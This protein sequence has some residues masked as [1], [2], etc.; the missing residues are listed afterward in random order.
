MLPDHGA[1]LAKGAAGDYDAEFT[2]LA[3]RLVADGLGASTLLLG[4]QPDDDTTPW[5]V[6]SVTAA[7]WY[8]AYWDRIEAAMSAV[9]GTSFTFEWDPGDSGTS[10]VPPSAM[11]PGDAAVD[12]IGTDAFDEVPAGVPASQQ[13]GGVLG[14]ADGP[15]W[16]ATFAR[17]HHK[18]LAV[19]MWGVVPTADGG[20]GD[21]AA[22][23]TDVL[24]WAAGQGVACCV[25][26]DYGDWAVGGGGFPAAYAALVT[27]VGSAVD[28]ATS[29][30]GGTSP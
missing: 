1:T 4:S 27:A 17:E 19:A 20:G 30:N 13:W 9:P 14:R 11:Y 28:A 22:Y 12:M 26:W 16:T 21:S 8:A 3:Q 5:Y 25:L 23:V 15:T 18:P 29:G 2:L 10:P 24:A 6:R 7:G